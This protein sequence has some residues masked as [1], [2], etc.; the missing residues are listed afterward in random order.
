MSIDSKDVE[1][2]YQKALRF[3]SEHTFVDNPKEATCQVHWEDAKNY[4]DLAI[5]FKEEFKEDGNWCN[6]FIDTYNGKVTG[7]ELAN[8][9][10]SEADEVTAFEEFAEKELVDY[11]RQNIIEN[12]KANEKF[13]YKDSESGYVFE[14]EKDSEYRPD[15][16]KEEG[17]I[18]VIKLYTSEDQ[19]KTGRLY[20][21]TD[22]IHVIDLK[23]NIYEER[24]ITMD[25]KLFIPYSFE[26]A[27]I[28]RE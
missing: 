23:K 20:A 2:D 15:I 13:A 9:D 19:Y 28:E 21:S 7:I 3:L 6:V 16:D 12:L 17:N 11:V 27:D 5:P 26:D 8:E 1:Y 14:F 10:Y 4:Y 22:D 25:E 24:F 18:V